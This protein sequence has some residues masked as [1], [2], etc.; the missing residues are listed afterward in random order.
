MFSVG[1]MSGG[2]TD[3]RRR[4]L[5]MGRMIVQFVAVILKF[6]VAGEILDVEPLLSVSQIGSLRMK[7]QIGGKK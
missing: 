5:Q 2:Y 3:R 4:R 1:C 7:A 6:V